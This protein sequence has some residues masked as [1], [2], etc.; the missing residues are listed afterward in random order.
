MNSIQN[1]DLT[2][3]DPRKFLLIKRFLCIFSSEVKNNEYGNILIS[4]CWFI[5]LRIL[6]LTEKRNF[7]ISVCN[8][9]RSQ[10]NSKNSADC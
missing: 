8:Q 1:Y 7:L 3:Y 10:Q 9:T 4:K 6:V 2:K 5:V